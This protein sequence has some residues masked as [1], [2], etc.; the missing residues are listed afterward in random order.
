MS[1]AALRD[2][3]AV[4]VGTDLLTSAADLLA[5]IGT[6]RGEIAAA[7]A[8]AA[9]QVLA[10]QQ[11]LAQVGL[12]KTEIEALIAA[13]IPG[14]EWT[15]TS[16][17]L[18]NPDGQLGTPVDL[19]GPAGPQGAPGPQ[20]VPGIVDYSIRPK[21]LSGAQYTLSVADNGQT[22]ILSHTAAASITLP[23]NMPTGFNVIVVQ[24]G[25]GQVLLTPAVGAT[26]FNV[27]NM[28][29]T[30]ARWASVAAFVYE[31][32]TGQA[33]RWLVSGDVVS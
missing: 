20:G 30:R 33:A 27:D 32:P 28:L 10:A 17:R 31:N 16:L 23:T 25:L 15:G 8:A 4:R 13:N 5:R 1:T 2:L 7:Q 6:V 21:I 29:R 9:A 24:G 19:R 12:R 11:V 14:H 26:A 3:A 18:R 22:V